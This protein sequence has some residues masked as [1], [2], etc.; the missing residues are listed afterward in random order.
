MAPRLCI[1]DSARMVVIEN[2]NPPVATSHH[3][4]DHPIQYGL[5]MYYYELEGLP[6]VASECSSESERP[7]C[8]V[9]TWFDRS[10]TFGLVGEWDRTVTQFSYNQTGSCYSSQGLTFDSRDTGWDKKTQRPEYGIGDVV[11]CGL[12]FSTWSIF[13]TKNGQLLGKSLFEQRTPGSLFRR[14]G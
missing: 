4:T 14:Y 6:V 2:R 9:Q 5:P 11:G 7:P 13:F 12:D 10:V 8:E 3:H 1:A